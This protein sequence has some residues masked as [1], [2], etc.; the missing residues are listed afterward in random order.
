MDSMKKRG[1]KELQPCNAARQR[2][3]IIAGGRSVKPDDQY[4]NGFYVSA[5][6]R[7]R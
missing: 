3:S 6:S 4:A 2:D 1:E 7:V 5:E